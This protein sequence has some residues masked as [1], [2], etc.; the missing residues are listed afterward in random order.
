MYPKSVSMNKLYRLSGKLW[1]NLPIPLPLFLSLLLFFLF[2][3]NGHAQTIVNGYAQVT[4]ITAVGGKSQLSIANVQQSGHSF[5]VNEP[6][7]VI[8]MQDDVIS[9]TSNDDDFGKLGAISSA[10]LFEEAIIDAVSGTPVIN[11]ITLRTKLGNTY[12]FGDN[13]SVQVVTFT[14]LSTGDFPTTNDITA[15]PWSASTGRGG[16]IAFQVPGKLTLKNNIN[17]DG[18]GFAGGSNSNNSLGTC[19]PSTYITSSTA[20]G[21]KG[22]GIYKINTT[23]NP[24]YAR[25]R[26]RV[27]T[28]GGGGSL[29]VAGGAGGGNY[30]AGG[31]GASAFACFLYSE[32]GGLGGVALNTQLMT[33]KR[34]YMGG[35]GG[36]GQG[37]NGKQTD[38]AAGGGIIII[39]AGSITTSCSSTVT[40]SA[41]G[42][43]ADDVG[44][45]APSA[46]AGGGGAA[47][48]IFL[49]VGTYN[50]PSSCKLNV[51]ANGG[52]GGS[53]GNAVNFGA[54]GG[55]GQGAVIYV[56]NPTSTTN[57]NNATAPGK[58]GSM[59]WGGNKTSGGAGNNNDG[60]LGG[61]GVILPVR[62]IYFAAENKNNTAV[63]NWTS[64][65]ESNV[66]Y[67]I[68]HSTDG[69][70]FTSIG[71]VK[72]SGK[73][74]YTFTDANPENGI[75][76]YRL[77]MTGNLGDKTTYSSVVYVNL[78]ATSRTAVAYPNPAHDHFSIR[79]QHDN[80]Y[81]VTISN[82]TGQVAYT[83][84]L[85]SVNNILTV[86]PG[87][88]LKPG[89]YMF[90][91]A[92]N[93][94][95]Q[96]GKLLIK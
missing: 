36:G 68:E 91:I 70:N 45:F 88:A 81:V 40:I 52:D 51:N 74:N 87:K 46:G 92:S 53:T 56:G 69:I 22:E 30:T 21:A 25:G 8:Q 55:G 90:K 57:V 72:G 75:N 80:M 78:T 7:I 19:A 33:G 14:K 82:L 29:N 18:V 38:G 94:N 47:G 93:G 10:G 2:T 3:F 31:D 77:V 44:G 59:S 13:S 37:S 73:V 5:I 66:T 63:L 24:T 23:A 95:E 1:C 28:G 12:N 17:A 27:L 71:M 50:V 62:L 26:A 43:A 76:Y 39:R 67:Q 32:T 83:G 54:G 84:T 49:Q 9:G 6:V 60:V 35:G 64:A 85:T 11:Q 89:W 4:G 41:N 16:I 61:I 65:D 15:L 42:N 48:S 34:L 86:I 96:S 79:V 20:V 58:G